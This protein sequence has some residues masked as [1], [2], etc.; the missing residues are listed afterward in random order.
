MILKLDRGKF[1]LS[2]LFILLLSISIPSSDTSRG[3]EPIQERYILDGTV[4]DNRTSTGLFNYSVRVDKEGFSAQEVRTD[5][6]GTYEF[7]LPPGNFTIFV[8]SPKGI[9]IGQMELTIGPHRTNHWDFELNPI[10]PQR[11][12]YSGRIIDDLENELE[13]AKVS[14]TQLDPY[15]INIT[16]TDS[17]GRFSLL[18]PSG[19]Y[20]LL[21]EYEGKER[22]NDTVELVWAEEKEAEIEIDLSD[23][24]SIFNDI[25]FFLSENW[26]DILF[27]IGTLLAILFLYGLFLGIVS[28]VRKRRKDL[29][30]SEWL[31]PIRRFIGRMTVLGV[32]MVVMRQ[33]ARIS[34]PVDEYVWTWMPRVGLSIAGSLFIILVMKVLLHGDKQFWEYIRTRTGAKG[35]V[36]L[37]QQLFSLLDIITR[38]LVMIIGGA[39]I[40]ILILTAFGLSEEIISRSGEF[41]SDNA[42]KMLFLVALVVITI[43]AKKLIDIFYQEVSSRANKLNPQVMAMGKKGLTGLIYFVIGLVFMFT[44][45]SIGGLGDIGQTFILVISMIV[46]LVVSFAATGSIGNMLSGLVL[47]SMKPFDIGDRIEVMNGLV[48][49]VMS[50][51]VMF[52]RI[53]DLEGRLIEIPNNNVLMNNITNF[54][55]SASDG[56]YAVFVDVTLG[57]DIHPKKVRSLL[58]R[59]AL[60]SPG[61]MKDPTPSV[62]VSSFENHA[63]AYRIRAYVEDPKNMMFIRSSVMESMLVIFHQEGLE[64]LSPLY[65]VKRDG[66]SPTVEELSDRSTPP[67]EDNMEIASGLTMFDDIGN[68]T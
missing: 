5:I 52:T 29:F 11:S 19:K 1:I 37:P 61:V 46:G 65:H 9:K 26:K 3:I 30:E 8:Y 50:T 13:G 51:G 49:D 7:I 12:L 47:V 53:K 24:R 4:T 16:I 54:S 57:Y 43:L 36:I 14:L 56:G 45:F 31:T 2:I 34:Q 42:G 10:Y 60:T 67:S 32:I 28:Q 38:Y 17:K 64:I 27:I 20:R 58:K 15:W 21:I 39:V 41:F 18:V 6:N 48:G 40:F 33:I 22:I 68:G 59:A 23:D 35:K 44:L 63:V 55:R 66:K 62:I 25:L